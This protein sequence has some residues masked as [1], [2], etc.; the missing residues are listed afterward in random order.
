[1]VDPREKIVS[2]PENKHLAAVLS[3]VPTLASTRRDFSRP[4]GRRRETRASRS[5]ARLCRFAG[6]VRACCKHSDSRKQQCVQECVRST[7][8]QWA[9]CPAAGVVLFLFLCSSRAVSDRRFRARTSAISADTYDQQRF[10]RLY[11]FVFFV[12]SDRA[13]A[14]RVSLVPDSSVAPACSRVGKRATR[15]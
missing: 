15:T 1:M 3:R 10:T 14:T 6:H 8:R 11:H 4:A 9:Q 7:S 12:V 13:S 5:S 2:V